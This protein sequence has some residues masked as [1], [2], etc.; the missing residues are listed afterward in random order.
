MKKT[1]YAILALALLGTPGFAQAPKQ[2]IKTIVN[3]A[4]KVAKKTSAKAA[5]KNAVNNV[6]SKQLKAILKT[7]L[8]SSKAAYNIHQQEVMG[9]MLNKE[10]EQA[11][12]MA[13]LKAHNE[14]NAL[15]LKEWTETVTADRMRWAAALVR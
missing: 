11:Q 8:Y 1:I 4:A 9:I 14:Q 12:K 2:T 10:L 13:L 5:A 7:D 15:I 3:K 6:S